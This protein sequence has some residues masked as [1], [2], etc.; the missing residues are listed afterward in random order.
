MSVDR[1]AVSL[2]AAL[3]QSTPHCTATRS[4]GAIHNLVIDLSNVGCREEEIA[5]GLS[6]LPS[7]EGGHLSPPVT[8]R[9]LYRNAFHAADVAVCLL[10][11]DRS[12]GQPTICLEIEDPAR[13]LSFV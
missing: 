9:R 11:S 3:Y 6:H 8:K 10:T 13:P 5:Y 12:R 1:E 7:A 4:E 2:Y